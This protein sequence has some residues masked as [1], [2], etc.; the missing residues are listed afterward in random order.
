MSEITREHARANGAHPVPESA[1]RGRVPGGVPAGHEPADAGEGAGGDGVPDVPV[2]R[3]GGGRD[4]LERPPL[5]TLEPLDVKLPEAL[6]IVTCVVGCWV[7]VIATVG[8]A[9]T[10]RLWPDALLFGAV[11][12]LVFGAII[13]GRLRT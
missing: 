3:E 2:G 10:G 12:T 1:V 6:A 8:W 7:G 13:R 9:V 4:R 11:P 5:P